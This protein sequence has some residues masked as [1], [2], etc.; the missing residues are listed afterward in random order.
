VVV[1]AS[2][3]LLVWSARRVLQN[4]YFLFLGFAYAL[5]A[6]AEFLHMLAFRGMGVFPQGGRTSPRSSGWWRA[7]LRRRRCCCRRW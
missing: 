2:V 4:D 3:F 5:V 6:G 1:A 7:G